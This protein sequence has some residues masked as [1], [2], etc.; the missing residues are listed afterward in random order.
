MNNNWW[1]S[2]TQLNSRMNEVNQRENAFDNLREKENVNKS[3]PVIEVDY[4]I[5][6]EILNLLKEVLNEVRGNS[7]R[8][9]ENK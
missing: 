5:L 1:N 3:N 6:K 8:N 9:E 2:K 4:N 7:N